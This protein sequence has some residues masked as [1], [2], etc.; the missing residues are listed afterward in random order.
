MTAFVRKAAEDAVLR[1]DWHENEDGSRLLLLKYPL[2]E[3]TGIVEHCFT[4]RL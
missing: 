4:T 3:R 1:E 2:L